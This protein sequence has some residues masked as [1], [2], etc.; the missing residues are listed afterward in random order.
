MKIMES[1][2]FEE[3]KIKALA[4]NPSKSYFSSKMS[5]A[6]KSFSKMD[7]DGLDI[8]KSSLFGS[9]G[10]WS[11]K[12]APYVCFILIFFFYLYINHSG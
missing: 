4:Q 2:K 6:E 11:S 10:S 5:E 7:L 3:Q 12:R 8:S 1:T 9:N